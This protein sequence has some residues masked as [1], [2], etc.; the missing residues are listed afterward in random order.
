MTKTQEELKQL[1]EEYEALT[2]KLKELTENELQQ[3]AGGAGDWYDFRTSIDYDEEV[4]NIILS[5]KDAQNGFRKDYADH[6]I[7]LTEIKRKFEPDIY[8]RMTIV[9]GMS[10]RYE[11]YKNDNSKIK[12]GYIADFI[13]Q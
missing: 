8:G 10:I 2:T 7:I 4:Q 13:Y 5:N 11:V 6:Y 12:D 1:K 3:V 9:V